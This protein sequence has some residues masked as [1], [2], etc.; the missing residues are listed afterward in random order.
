MKSGK[1][2]ARKMLVK[3]KI[4]VNFTNILQAA[5]M[6]VDSESVKKI[7]NLTVI[8]THLGSVCLKSACKMLM[9]QFQVLTKP[10]KKYFDPVRYGQ[11]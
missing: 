5:F 4:G 3:L 9:G 11:N 6:L 1:K 7:D 10:L 2:A 8:F